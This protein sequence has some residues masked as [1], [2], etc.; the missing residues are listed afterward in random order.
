MPE[1]NESAI[2]APEITPA[3]ELIPAQQPPKQKCRKEYQLTDAEGKPIGRP[4]VF[5]GDTWEEVTDKIATAH[6]HASRKISDLR[7]KI[8]PDQQD[9]DFEFKSRELTEEEKW[10][11][12]TELSNPATVDAALDKLLE[13]KLGAPPTK[14]QE[15]LNRTL[16]TDRIQRS[17]AEAQAF[18]DEHPEFKV[19]VH[20]QNAMTKFMQ[21]KNLAWTK[22]NLEFAFEQLQQDGLVLLNDPEPEVKPQPEGTTVPVEVEQR[23]EPIAPPAPTT[24]TRPRGTASSTGLFSQHSSA[25]R[26]ESAA[27]KKSDEA[28][29]KEVYKMTSDEYKRRISTDAQF[30]ARVNAVF[31]PKK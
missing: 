24:G 29:A 17:R 21:A 4:Q 5:E 31:A 15:A 22:K 13:A 8:K 11:L 25:S 18:I 1:T 3:P 19:C 10:K 26:S 12:A 20:N 2:P 30:R 6:L 9:P 14:V 23:Q 16:Q 27:Q 28:F 7:Q